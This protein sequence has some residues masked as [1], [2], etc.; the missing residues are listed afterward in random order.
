[1]ILDVFQCSQLFSDVFSWVVTFMDN[2]P[3]CGH[4]F[5]GCPQ[6]I[7]DILYRFSDV[8]KIC[9]DVLRCSQMFSDDHRCFWIF[10]RY[11]ID[12]LLMFSRC[13]LDV[14]RMFAGFF[15]DVFIMLRWVLWAWWN[16][17]II[18]SESMDFNDPK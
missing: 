8:F 12:V 16:L 4:F 1:M 17:M 2:H 15:Q 14:L 10:S 11:S 9:S 5:S 3:L 13:S 7:T 6:L 18:S